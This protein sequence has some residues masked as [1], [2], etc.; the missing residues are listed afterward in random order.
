MRRPR[1]WY[2]PCLPETAVSSAR[3][4]H[5][6]KASR[7]P[8]VM[9]TAPQPALDQILRRDRGS[10]IPVSASAS[11]SFESRSPHP[12]SA[13]DRAPLPRRGIQNGAHPE[14]ARKTDRVVHRLHRHL[15]LQHQEVRPANTSA[16]AATSAGVSRSFA[17]LHDPD[18]ILSGRLHENGRDPARKHPPSHG[19]TGYRSRASKFARV[20]GPNRS[21]PTRATIATSP[22]QA[23]A[24]RLPGWRPSPKPQTELAPKMVSPDAETDRYK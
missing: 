6:H 1:L 22:P 18:A 23:A 21:S 7:A 13:P 8:N 2:R 14:P 3:R 10:T 4:R 20:A 11:V 24:P 5:P 12:R 16:A 15:Q 17:P 9:I 19:R